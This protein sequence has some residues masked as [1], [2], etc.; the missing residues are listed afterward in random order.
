MS[1]RSAKSGQYTT[2]GYAAAHPATT[3]VERKRSR[4]V[5]KKAKPPQIP[6]A[7]TNLDIGIQP[8]PRRI[9]VTPLSS[10]AVGTPPKPLV[11]GPGKSGK[12][13][14]GAYRWLIEAD[15]GD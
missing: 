1:A 4:T 8:V 7:V 5:A 14:V 10:G 9:I 15:F 6:F 2:R 3:V 11:L 12:G 13:T